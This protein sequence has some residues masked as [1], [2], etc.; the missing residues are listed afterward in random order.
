M[1][2]KMDKNEEMI[3]RA[4]LNLPNLSILNHKFELHDDVLAGYVMRSLNGERFR[5]TFIAFEKDEFNFISHLI[6]MNYNREDGHNLITYLYTV[7]LVCNILNK[8]QAR[9]TPDNGTLD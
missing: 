1:V 9:K 8:Y 3:L 6:N 5:K 7:K 2:T 4:F